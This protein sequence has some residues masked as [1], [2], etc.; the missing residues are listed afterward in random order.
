[1]R[2]QAALLGLALLGAA[3]A[4]TGSSVA[5]RS[6]D[7]SPN[8]HMNTFRESI[9]N[10]LTSLNL[11]QPN[12]RVDPSEEQPLVKQITGITGGFSTLVAALAAVGAGLSALIAVAVQPLQVVNHIL[13][14][15][16]VAMFL[17]Y[18]IEDA[19]YMPLDV[20]E[21]IDYY[22]GSSVLSKG[23]EDPYSPV[24]SKGIEDPYYYGYDRSSYPH[25]E[26]YYESFDG[27]AA[28]STVQGYNY[29]SNGINKPA[30]TSFGLED[31]KKIGELPLS[32][33]IRNGHKN[34]TTSK[35]PQ[36]VSESKTK[37]SS[38][39][40]SRPDTHAFDRMTSYSKVK[41]KS[42]LSTLIYD[43]LN[44]DSKPASKKR[45]EKTSVEEE[46]VR[47]NRRSFVSAMMNDPV[48]TL[49]ARG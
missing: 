49:L 3:G 6:L 43:S 38:A 10:L 40:K 24:L 14:V 12:P 9:L 11:L 31:V 8:V 7:V 1:M 4:S 37:S 19:Y 28:S 21:R 35:K 22:T 48:L 42:K 13:A 32:S 17:T 45:G 2:A 23:L 18:I 39:L 36:E 44:N 16:A 30:P 41:P 5:N 15:V 20:S 33:S 47:R 46:V 29:G 26:D 25:A 34:S 27:S